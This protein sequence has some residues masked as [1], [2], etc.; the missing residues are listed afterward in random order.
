MKTILSIR[1]ISM[2]L[3]IGVLLTLT[4]GI[5]GCSDNQDPVAPQASQDAVSF[6]VQN[7]NVRK[8]MAI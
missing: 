1:N 5:W 2:I 6:S 4:F 3:T 8:V 7:A